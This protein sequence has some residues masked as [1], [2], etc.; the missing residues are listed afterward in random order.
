MLFPRLLRVGQVR[1]WSGTKH[2]FWGLLSVYEENI[3]AISNTSIV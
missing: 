1:G 3:S 2:P